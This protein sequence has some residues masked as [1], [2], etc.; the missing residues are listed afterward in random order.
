MY[1]E[2]IELNNKETNNSIKKWT[3]PQQTACQ[4]TDT[5]GMKAYG[6]M[7]HLIRHQGNVN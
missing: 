3:K 4:R 2:L 5:N 6:K 1:K 7:P